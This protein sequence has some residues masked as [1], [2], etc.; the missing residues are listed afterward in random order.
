MLSVVKTFLYRHFFSNLAGMRLGDWWA[1]LAEHHFRVSGR[2]WPRCVFVTLCALWATISA[3]WESFRYRSAWEQT[4]I[5]PPIFILGHWRS[6]TTLLHQLLSLDD[7]FYTPTME[8]VLFP[9]SILTGGPMGFFMNLFLP[10]D[11]G[12]DQVR[13]GIHEPFED[14]FALTIMSR[15]SPYL[16]WTFPSHRDR[17]DTQLTLDDEDDQKRWST[18]MRTLVAKLTLKRGKPVL[19]KSPPHTA[20]LAIL[21]KLFPGAKFIQIHRDP[22]TVYLSTTNPV[23]EGLDGLRL[24]VDSRRDVPS[25]VF[26]RYRQLYQA[27]LRDRSTISPDSLAEISYADL[28]ADPVPLLAAVYQSLG[29][30]GF[31]KVGPKIER[32]LSANHSY[33]KNT[34]PVL[35]PDLET[36]IETEWGEIYRALLRR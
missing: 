12:V 7:R 22:L 6:G 15:V 9:H 19:L 27:Y 32:W 24:Q 35:E 10:A 20:R 33:R 17:H 21:A 25:E 18:A 8:D 4:A 3:R 26:S 13:L 31:E 30:P 5:P 34:H 36:R 14:E 16:G 28:E 29:L 11:R 2:Y 23:T 1:L